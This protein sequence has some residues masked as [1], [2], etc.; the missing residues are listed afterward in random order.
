[1]NAFFGASIVKTTNPESAAL[2]KYGTPSFFHITGRISYH[3]T[4]SLEGM[5][6]ES[7]IIYKGNM[8]T[9]R[10][11]DQLTINRLDLWNYSYIFNFKF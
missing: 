7:L 3:F 5:S 9:E 4:G 11:S 8:E 6:I 2:N 1:M 10:N